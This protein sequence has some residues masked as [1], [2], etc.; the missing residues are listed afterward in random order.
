MYI[1]YFTYLSIIDVQFTVVMRVLT[2]P[3]FLKKKTLQ[4][5]L[6]AMYKN[7]RFGKRI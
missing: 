2:L 1:Y 3:F 7:I 4:Q 6:L 5:Y